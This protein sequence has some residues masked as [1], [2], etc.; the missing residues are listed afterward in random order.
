M[1][2][3]FMFISPNIPINA[4][5][6]ISEICTRQNCAW[7]NGRIN[8][9]EDFPLIQKLFQYINSGI[10]KE[11]FFYQGPIYRIH[12]SYS[13]LKEYVDTDKEFITSKVWSDG[14]CRVLPCTEETEKLCA[15]SKSFD[16]TKFDKVI[17]DEMAIFLSCNTG[18]LYGIDINVLLDKFGVLNRFEKEQEVLFPIQNEFIIKEYKC[19][20]NKFNYYMRKQK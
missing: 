3:V 1:R 8:D 11:D 17:N 10:P 20:P 13:T 14:S 16:F 6:L 19:T 5:L 9:C 12:T 15:F 4:E 18:N 2:G 7:N